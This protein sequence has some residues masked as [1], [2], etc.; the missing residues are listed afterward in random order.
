MLQLVKLEL[1][2]TVQLKSKVK[3]CIMYVYNKLNKFMLK[4][5][6]V[7]SSRVA[8]KPKHG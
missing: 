5:Q 8:D 2:G 7:Q 6:D 3:I 1:K 4:L